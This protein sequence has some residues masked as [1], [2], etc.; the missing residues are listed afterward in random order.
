MHVSYQTVYLRKENP[1]EDPSPPTP[2]FHFVQSVRGERRHPSRCEAHLVQ[3]NHLRAINKF[4][5]QSEEDETRLGQPISG[6]HNEEGHIGD[7]QWGDRTRGT[8]GR[9]WACQW[10]RQL[11]L[12]RSR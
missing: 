8:A 7:S 5:P 11:C 10:M 12:E 4:V 9:G 1:A 3:G 2:R 6:R